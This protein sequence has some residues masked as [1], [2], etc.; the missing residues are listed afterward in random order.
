MRGSR[1]EIRPLTRLAVRSWLRE[2]PL[3]KLK[4]FCPLAS[5]FKWNCWREGT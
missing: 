3:V 1:G 4:M 5:A 2:S